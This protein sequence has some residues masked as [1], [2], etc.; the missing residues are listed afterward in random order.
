MTK[1]LNKRKS[2]S[3]S[4]AGVKP[5]TASETLIAKLAQMIDEKYDKLSDDEIQASQRKLKALRD[6]VRASHAPKH[7]TA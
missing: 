2:P 4:R 1:L 3:M 5:Q 6:R 7:G